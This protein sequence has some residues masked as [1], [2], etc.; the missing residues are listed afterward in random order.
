MRRSLLIPRFWMVAEVPFHIGLFIKYQTTC[1]DED[2][3]GISRRRGE[4]ENQTLLN[5]SLDLGMV[6]GD[7]VELSPWKS[8]K[9]GS[10]SYWIDHSPHLLTTQRWA[11]PLLRRGQCLYPRRRWARGHREGLRFFVEVSASLI[12]CAVSVFTFVLWSPLHLT[13]CVNNVVNT[14]LMN[15]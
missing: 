6:R 15:G 11:G 2:C 8:L 12:L 4:R 7:V 14:S 3:C 10:Y 9:W 5:F 1:K 13:C